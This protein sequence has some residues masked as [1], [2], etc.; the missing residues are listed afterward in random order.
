MSINYND[1]FH[2]LENLKIVVLGI[3]YTRPGSDFFQSLTDGHPEIIQTTG[4]CLYRYHGF[5]GSAVSK[6]N[7]Q[8]LVEE[9]IYFPYHMPLFD[10]RFR[11]TERWNKLGVNKNEHFEVDI[12]LFRQHALG[13]M[14]GKEVNFRNF[15]LAVHGAYALTLGQNIKNAKIIF[16]HI[17]HIK[18]WERYMPD[19]P[20]FKIIIM[21]RDL[22]DGLVSYIEHRKPGSASYC[23]PDSHIAPLSTYSSI[24]YYVK[25]YD[26]VIFLSLRDLHHEPSKILSCFCKDVNIQ[27]LPEILLESSYHGKLWWGDIM[28]PKFINGFNP[29]FGKINR[30][31]GKLSQI[32]N[33]IIEFLYHN[34]F[35]AFNHPRKHGNLLYYVMYLLAPIVIFKPMRYEMKFFFYQVRRRDMSP[36]RKIK[37]CLFALLNYLVRIKIYLVVYFRKITL[38]KIKITKYGDC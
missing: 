3:D 28:S 17:H 31:K 35:M 13:F 32:D 25:K 12:P 11:V 5:W 7:V 1:L 30:W 2:H 27:F 36:T 21:T 19:F 37:F 34:Q 14:E 26:D 20:N 6:D 33:L 29:E 9:F 22:R 15:F 4:T 18:N 38:Q 16:Y 8:D 23:R 10:S 24:F